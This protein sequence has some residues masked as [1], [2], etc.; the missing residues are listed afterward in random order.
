MAY[1]FFIFAHSDRMAPDGASVT[2]KFMPLERK[3]RWATNFFIW[4]AVAILV[5]NA[6]ESFDRWS[7]I[8]VARSSSLYTL[9]NLIG[10]VVG[11]LLHNAWPYILVLLNGLVLRRYRSRIAAGL[12]VALGLYGVG[13]SLS[14]LWGMGF[15]PLVAALVLFFGL[16]LLIAAWIFVTLARLH[17]DIKVAT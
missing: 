2:G 14:I 7:E 5:V 15:S 6:F 3:I 8:Y 16:Y 17:R 13:L 4:S 1:P 9:A 10:F 12:F 11:G